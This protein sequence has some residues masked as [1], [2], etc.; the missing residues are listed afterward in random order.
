[1]IKVSKLVLPLCFMLIPCCYILI[2]TATEVYYY[3]KSTSAIEKKPAVLPNRMHRRVTAFNQPPANMPS[4]N[5]SR[6]SATDFN[7]YSG[8][9]C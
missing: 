7:S 9:A 6:L 8:E 5:L 2:W 3:K 4:Q 1:M